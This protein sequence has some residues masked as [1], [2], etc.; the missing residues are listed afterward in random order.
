MPMGHHVLPDQMKENDIY[1]EYLQ[2]WEMITTKGKKRSS[3]IYYYRQGQ[4]KVHTDGRQGKNKNHDLFVFN[5]ECSVLFSSSLDLLEVI[6]PFLCSV[7]W[8]NIDSK[9]RIHDFHFAGVQDS[10][11]RHLLACFY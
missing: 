2:R 7:L 1:R 6:H 11:Q 4:K 3:I 10:Q 5:I 8:H 9:Q